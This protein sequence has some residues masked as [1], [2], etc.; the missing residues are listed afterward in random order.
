MRTTLDLP[1]GL[2]DEARDAMGF[3]SKTETGGHAWREVIRR[4]RLEEV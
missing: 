2:I 4:T 3:T 1:D